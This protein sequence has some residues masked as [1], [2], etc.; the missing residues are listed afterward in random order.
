MERNEIH[1]LTAAYALDALDAAEE[2][3]YEE[4][5]A[6]C[7]SCQDELAGLR[8]TASLL[9]FVPEGPAP[10]PRLRAQILERARDER[11][12][13]VP[14]RARRLPVVVSTAAA[15]VAAVV[16]LGVGIWAAT[17]SNDLERERELV[18]VLGHPQ[19]RALELSG[20]TGSVVVA[21]DGDAV[22][23]VSRLRGAPQGKTYEIWVIAG[24]RPAPAGL[25]SGEDDRDVVRLTRRVPRG[26]RIAV[27]VE[28]AGGVDQP[29]TDPLFATRASA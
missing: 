14:F 20:A 11:A 13:V 2:R 4:H 9:A 29:T 10:P 24:G 5:L 26:G 15:A 6:R 28:R 21:P 19:A 17:L 25:F 3:A 27:T 8:E 22:L 18:A 16:A 23:V 7:S 12:T 1:A